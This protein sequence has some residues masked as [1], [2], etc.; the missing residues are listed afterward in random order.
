MYTEYLNEVVSLISNS[1]IYKDQIKIPE[2]ND[3][4]GQ[5][6]DEFLKVRMN[7]GKLFF[8]GNGGS[9]AIASHMTA[10]FMKNGRIRTVSLYDSATLT[11]LGNDYGYEEVFS[12]QLEYLV[13]DGDLLVC[14]SSS[15]NSENIVN[16]IKTAYE[17]GAKVVALTGFKPDNKVRQMHGYHIY[18]PSECY[19]MVESVHNLFLQQIVDEIMK[20]DNR[21][22]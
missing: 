7:G 22:E 11:C 2:W 6:V 17:K 14:I 16:A 5:I 18:V 1:E 9:A 10:D 19:G 8:C 12:R 20:K 21:G 3:A 13:Q 4:F 15:G